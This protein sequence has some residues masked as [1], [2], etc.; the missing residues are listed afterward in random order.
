MQSIK[1][2]LFLW[3]TTRS[4]KKMAQLPSVEAVREER[5]RTAPKVLKFPKGVRSETTNIAG[6]NAQWLVPEGCGDER[7]L[8]YFHGGAYITGS[9][10][11][12]RAL[13][14]QLAQKAGVKGLI[15]DYRLA[16]ENPYP[17]ALD[18]AL[19]I[20]QSLLE[21]F[22]NAQIAFAG[23]SAGGGLALATAVAIQ[24]QQM[25]MP[26][27][28]ALMS[29]WVDLTLS[30][31]THITKAPVD[32]YFPDK[33]RLSEAAVDYCVDTPLDD[34]GV[35]PLFASLENLPPML[36]HTGGREALLDDSRLLIEKV[37]S[38]SGQAELKIW[39]QMW[40]VW[41][42]FCGHFREADESVSELSDFVSTH[43]A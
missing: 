30:A 13:A 32:P 41:Q 43:M 12:H 42:A 34:L 5:D 17:A 37:R 18:D 16:P 33:Q 35:S 20:Y 31:D 26:V 1:S 7:I 19:A 39:P 9:C 8:L 40:H 27:A 25:V 6:C 23:D 24:Q 2:R 10:L 14:A 22:P 4:L 3:L 15:F 28:L 38:S 29:P 36:V 11:T 21:Q